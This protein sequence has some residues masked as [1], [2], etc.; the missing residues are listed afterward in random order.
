MHTLLQSKLGVCIRANILNGL[1]FCQKNL[2]EPMSG[3]IHINKQGH[4][5]CG[6]MRVCIGSESCIGI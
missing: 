1:I 3:H 6:N 5:V 2:S 4:I